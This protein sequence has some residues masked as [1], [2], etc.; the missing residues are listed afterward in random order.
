MST[1]VTQQFRSACKLAVALAVGFA[2]WQSSPALA[3]TVTFKDGSPAPIV[4]GTYTGTQDNV[5]F[6]SSPDVNSGTEVFFDVGD[7]GQFG[8]VRRTLVRFDVTALA[9]QYSQINSITLNLYPQDHNDVLGTGTNTNTMQVFQ[10]SAANGAWVEGTTAGGPQTGSA[11]WA[12]RAYHPSTPTPW[13][14]S[15]GLSTSGTD[16]D[17]IAL[18]SATWNVSTPVN[19]AGQPFALSFVGSS[20]ALTSLIDAWSSGSNPGMFLRALNEPGIGS[21]VVMRVNSAENGNAALHP[22][23]VVN[24]TDIPEP[25]SLGL[26]GFGGFMLVARRRRP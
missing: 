22:E 12:N 14:G 11:S 25:A 16:Y 4:G 21:Y 18:A 3:T 26:L 19:D 20:A 24:F 13:A 9:G 2:G 6:A 8:S 23:L 7:A 15:A 17:A 10:V 1:F 5:M